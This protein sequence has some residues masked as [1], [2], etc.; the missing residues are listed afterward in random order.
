[1][2]PEQLGTLEGMRWSVPTS[3]KKQPTR[4]ITVRT[5]EQIIR[6]SRPYPKLCGIYFLIR[7]GRI[8][9][10]GQAVNIFARIATHMARKDF[11]SWS[12]VKCSAHQLSEFE[13]AYI[14][15]FMPEMNKDHVTRKIRADAKASRDA[16]LP[17]TETESPEHVVRERNW[18]RNWPREQSA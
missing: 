4:K 13:R 7:A 6:S 16:M 3:T 8:V 11:D 9:Y 18:P 2:T 10:I 1:M 17:A 5:E 12:H 15:K 14:N